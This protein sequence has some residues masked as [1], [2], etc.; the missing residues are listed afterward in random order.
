[1]PNTLTLTG[2]IYKSLLSHLLPGDGL[3][4]A[5][6]LLCHIGRGKEG[7][8]FMVKEC[9]PVPVSDCLH[10]SEDRLAWHF[11]KFFFP[12]E[13]NRNRQTGPVYHYRT[14]SPPWV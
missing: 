10:R 4:S 12:G 11:E 3:E 8:R 14:Q 7:F 13:N 9:V 2:S 6:I 1:M 5:A